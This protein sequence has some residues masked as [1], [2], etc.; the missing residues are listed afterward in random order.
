MATSGTTR[1]ELDDRAPEGTGGMTGDEQQFVED[2]G[3]YFESAAGLPRTAGR[4]LGY[5]LVCDPPG[6]S[7]EQLGADLGASTGSVS[8]TTRALIRMGFVERVAVRGDRRAHYRLRPHAW[9]AALDETVNQ[10]RSLRMLAERGLTSPGGAPESRRRRLEEMREMYAYFEAE[11]P[12][13]IERYHRTH[14]AS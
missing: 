8:T 12:A 10:M 4:M 3:L 9:V 13:L 1:A 7:A 2:A 14:P 5:L 6:R 11:Y